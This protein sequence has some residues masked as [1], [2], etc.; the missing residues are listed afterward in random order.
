MSLRRVPIPSTTF[1]LLRR[2][3]SFFPSALR[4]RASPVRHQSRSPWPGKGYRQQGQY[5]RFS[6]VQTIKYLWQHSTGFRYGV[7]AAGTGVVGFVGYNIETV[8]VSGRKRFNWV[9]PEYEEQMGME[10]Y[11]QVMQEFRS[12]ILPEWHPQT[13]LV[14]RVLHRLIPSSGLE[15]QKWEVNVIDDKEQMNAFV[16]PG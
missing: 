6:R 15:G 13:Q 4:H 8:P 2:P 1:H 14:Q 3:T 7:G 11:K 5:N 10:Q 12:R 16:I 9:N